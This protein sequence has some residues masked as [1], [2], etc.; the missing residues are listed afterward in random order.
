MN[1]TL[2]V[3]RHEFLTIV[4]KPSFWFGMLG[5]PFIVGIIV[6][7]IALA[8]GAATA[9]VV[10]QRSARPSK[11][12]G[13]VDLSGLVKRG[14]DHFQPFASEDQARSALASGQIEAYYVVPADFLQTGQVRMVANEIDDTPFSPRNQSSAFGALIKGNLLSDQALAKQVTTPVEIKDNIALAPPEARKGG[15]F[16]GFSPLGYG[17]AMLF[18]IVL[19]TAS[20]FLMQAVSTEKENRVIEVLM[21]SVAP[22][23]LLAGKILGLGLIG[24]IQLA[25]WF[26]SALFTLTSVPLISRFVGPISGLAVLVTMVFFVLGYFIYASLLAGLGAL[27]PGGRETAQYSILVLAPLFIPIYLNQ[28]IGAEPAGP[29]ATVLSLIPLTAP[30]V[31]PMRLFTTD[32]P[33]WQ[34]GVS[35]GLLVGFDFLAIAGAARV[36]RAQS[37]LSGSKPSFGQ[38]LQAFRA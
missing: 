2:V 38:V 14:G 5:M 28:A 34:V 37:L 1:K 36:F 19:M 11:P 7:I 26:G 27:M 6:A 17:V 3:L 22:G 33:L 8:G 30:I 9:S 29:L 21:S 16:G 4:K 15:S 10:S 31:M 12:Q 25:L 13:Y 20:A 24:L 18:F 23:Q 35:F 32:V